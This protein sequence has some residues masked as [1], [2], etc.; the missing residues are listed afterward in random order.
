MGPLIKGPKFF[1]YFKFHIEI[2]LIINLIFNFGGN[3]KIIEANIVDLWKVGKTICVTTNGFIKKNNQG[4]MGAGNALAIAKEIP[5]LPSALG[6]H[7]RLR[8]NVVGYIHD[9]IISFPTKPQFGNYDQVIDKAKRI[10]KPGQKIPGYH[11]KSDLKLI[12]DGIERLNLII[13]KQNLDEVYLPL[14]GVNNGQLSFEEVEPILK[15]GSEKII[16]C[17]M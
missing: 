17:K 16:F 6:R 2:I 9:R 11:C 13:E 15:K 4:V 1:Y 3:V 10:Y 7:I 8:G 14:P 12:E 5:N